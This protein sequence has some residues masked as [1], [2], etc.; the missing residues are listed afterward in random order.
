MW[1]DLI[2]VTSL[3]NAWK[4]IPYVIPLDE[5][6]ISFPSSWR[7]QDKEMRYWPCSLSPIWRAARQPPASK[8]K[9]ISEWPVVKSRLF[10]V[11]QGI[12]I[13]FHTAIAWA[14]QRIPS[15]KQWRMKGKERKKDREPRN[16]GIWYHLLREY[17]QRYQIPGLLCS[18]YLSFLFHLRTWG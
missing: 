3:A 16:P 8:R 15:P 13:S 9:R 7:D 12:T 2:S 10:M 17:V 4:L 18:L 14:Y 1:R 6:G 5:G 11:A